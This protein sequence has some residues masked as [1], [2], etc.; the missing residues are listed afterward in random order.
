MKKSITLLILL[1][2]FFIMAQNNSLLHIEELKKEFPDE[3]IVGV[4]LIEN[5]IIEKCKEKK[6]IY[7]EG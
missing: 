5:L 6:D 4:N 2:S 1:S 3:D 7:G